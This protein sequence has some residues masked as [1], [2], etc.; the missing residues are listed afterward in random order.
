MMDIRFD[1][2]DL[3]AKEEYKVVVN[4]LT[5]AIQKANEL[6]RKNYTGA[7]HTTYSSWLTDLDSGIALKLNFDALT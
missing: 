7:T 5:E 4:T 3:D 6:K 2:Y 1:I